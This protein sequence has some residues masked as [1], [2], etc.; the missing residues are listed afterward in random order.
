MA[1]RREPEGVAQLTHVGAVVAMPGPDGPAILIV[2]ASRPPFDWVLPK[3]HIE[4]GETPEQAA[5]REVMEEA[6]VDAEIL[7]SLGDTTFEVKGKEIRVRHFLM[8]RLR[9]G[10]AIE[11][12]ETRWCSPADAE[13]LL[14]FENAREV[15]RRAATFAGLIDAR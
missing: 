4:A 7:T 12:R 11:S 1:S 5:R 3:G 8:R 14:P 9:E 6:G 13:R 2:R 15:V 10:T